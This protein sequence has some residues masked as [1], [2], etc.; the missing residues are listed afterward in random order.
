LLHHLFGGNKGYEWLTSFLGLL[1]TISYT[2]RIPIKRELIMTQYRFK[3]LTILA[4]FLTSNLLQ[5]D[6][7]ATKA[8]VQQLLK[9]IEA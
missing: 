2:R 1:Q 7:N 3:L 5:F 4:N 6:E 8:F 9:C